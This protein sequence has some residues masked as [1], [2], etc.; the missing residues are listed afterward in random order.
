[1]KMLNRHSVTIPVVEAD[2]QLVGLVTLRDVL[3]P[4]YPN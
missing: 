2:N 1:M 4:L 3:L